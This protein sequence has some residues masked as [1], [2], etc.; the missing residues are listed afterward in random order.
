MTFFVQVW[1][2]NEFPKGDK[3][4]HTYFANELNSFKTAPQGLLASDSRLRPDRYA[5]EMGDLGKAGTDKT[6][7][8]FSLLYVVSGFFLLEHDGIAV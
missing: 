1:K 3:F 5:L 4:Q 8:R 2:C 7:Y 6:R